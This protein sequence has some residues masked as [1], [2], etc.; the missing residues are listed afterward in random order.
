MRT[1]VVPHEHGAY[2][3]ILIPTIT[4]L[5]VGR[6][7]PAAVALAAAG[8]GVFL[9]HEPLLVILGLRGARSLREQRATA[10][11]SLL[12]FGGVALVAGLAA[13]AALD[14][15]SRVAALVPFGLA[16]CA[17]G[18]MVSG[19]E[20]TTAGEVIVGAALASLSLPVA[21]ASGVPSAGAWTVAAVFAAAFAM[22]TV[23]VRAVIARPAGASRGPTRGAALAVVSG[24]FAVL[25]FLAGRGVL[26][27]SAAIASSPVLIL[28]GV[29]LVVAPSARHLRTIGWTLVAATA[30]TS[31]ILISTL[32]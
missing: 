16:V 8:F 22:A 25:V 11:R 12:I 1:A 5:A 29:L 24:L 2:G 17:G 26:A 13:L 32:R 10:W 6:A 3:Q 31:A 23:T 30:G 19:L 4:A 20:R 28:T 7:G 15:E 18:L 14:V 21:L 27:S 9:A